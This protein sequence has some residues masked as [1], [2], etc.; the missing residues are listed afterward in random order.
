M[1]TPFK[2]WL[3][4]KN[5]KR[6][7]GSDNHS[8]VHP[9]ILEA[10]AMANVGHVPSYGT[11]DVSI[12][13]QGIFKQKFGAQ[14]Q[15]HFVFNG[16]AANVMA[17]RL[18]CDTFHSVLCSDV[19]HLNVDECG[20]P[21]I[22]GHCKLIP[23]PS[24]HGKMRLQDL[25]KAL[26]RKG[27]QHFSQ[28]RAVSL[29][30]PTEYGTLYTFSEMQEIISW[31]KSE[32]LLVHIDGA[33][34]SNAACLMNKTFKELTTDLGVDVVSFGGTKNGLL[35]GEAV[36]ILNQDLKKRAPYIRKQLAQL[37]SKSRFVAAQ[38]LAYFKNDLW[39]DLASHSMK[40]AQELRLLIEGTP[41]IEITQ[42]TD[43]NAVFVKFPQN[44]VKELRESHFFYV[45]DENTYECRLMT[46][47]DTEQEDVEAFAE[48]IKQL[49]KMGSL[50]QPGTNL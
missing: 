29:T 47:W 32:N 3:Q 27:D 5:S 18:M 41:H 22:L 15:A 40:R 35:F 13:T 44:W 2:P 12:E 43:S 9:Q 28:V 30:Q 19:S 1:S 50:Q 14:A 36:V 49:S 26:I 24:H 7:F 10:I 39:K 8:G 46:S 42:P 38:F 45:W 20:A 23:I 21:E 34:F 48:K 37:P 6:G 31:A 11:D 16:T 17:L 25:K 33:R 4:I